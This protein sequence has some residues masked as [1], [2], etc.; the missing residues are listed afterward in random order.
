MS[1]LW[2]SQRER[3]CSKKSS[4]W[5]IQTSE[6][7]VFSAESVSPREGGFDEGDVPVDLCA[8][9]EGL[10]VGGVH[11]HGVD[12]ST[13]ADSI[14]GWRK[15]KTLSG[16]LFSIQLF[17]SEDLCT[18]RTGAVAGFAALD[19]ILLHLVG[20]GAAGTDA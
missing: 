8:I 14:T 15:R 19:S 9:P 12:E 4:L 7:V 20:S 11:S 6:K 18:F 10:D 17:S 1:D 5:F 13:N 3:S 2:S 16:F